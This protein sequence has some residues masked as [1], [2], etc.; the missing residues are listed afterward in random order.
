[1]YKVTKITIYDTP[2]NDIYTYFIN[3][4][5]SKLFEELSYSEITLENKMNELIA[6]VI[7]ENLYVDYTDYNIKVFFGLKNPFT[8][9]VMHTIDDVKIYALM[10]YL[11]AENTE[12][13]DECAQPI[14]KHNKN[15]VHYRNKKNE[16]K[17]MK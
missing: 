7:L 2:K 9:E 3:L 17:K 10:F 11:Y 8:K 6:D 1:M 15:C 13:C 5:N 14:N 16:I 12:F 4:Y